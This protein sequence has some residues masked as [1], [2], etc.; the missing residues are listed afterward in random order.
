MVRD[1]TNF[2]KT[3][4]EAQHILKTQIMTKLKHLKC[5]KIKNLKCD[6]TQ[7]LKKTKKLKKKIDK[8]NNSNSDQ[9]YKLKL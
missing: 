4:F 1:N 5:G 3:D 9:T 7:N 6:K 2:Y 8:T